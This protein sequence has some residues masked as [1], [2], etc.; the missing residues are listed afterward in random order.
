MQKISHTKLF[1]DIHFLMAN[2]LLAYKNYQ[3]NG[4]TYFYAKEL[5]KCNSEMIDILKNYDSFFS[6]DIKKAAVA[7]LDHYIIWRNKWDELKQNLNPNEAD[8]FIFPNEHT[9]PKWAA[10]VFE[11]EYKKYSS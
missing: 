6:N 3:Q 5:R 8:V 9:F 2:S 1:S 7:L 10:Q 11:E 4:K